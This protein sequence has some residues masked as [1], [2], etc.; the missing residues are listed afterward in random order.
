[1]PARILFCCFLAAVYSS[2]VLILNVDNR[3]LDPKVESTHYPTVSALLNKKYADH[4]G[5]DFIYV[6]ESIENLVSDVNKQ[7]SSSNIIPPTD[8]HKDAASAFHVGLKQFRAASWAKLPGIWYIIAH[9][10]K[11][12]DY[13]F[14]IDSDAFISPFHRDRSVDDLFKLYSNPSLITR[15][16]P[17]V[18]ESIF[19]FFHNHPWR[20]DMPCAGTC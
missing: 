12:Y 13:V 20:D 19:V 10:T 14:Y 18:M 3:D 6:R 1:M 5:Y 16:N 9:A 7:Y 15:G 8:N 17:N 4:H 2:K 11:E